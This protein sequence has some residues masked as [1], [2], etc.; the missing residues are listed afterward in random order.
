MANRSKFA[1][2]ETKYGKSISEI[3]VDKL[4]HFGNAQDAA[5]DLR[6]SYHHFV[7]KMNELGIVKEPRYRLPEAERE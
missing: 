1:A 6:I 2:L 7:R 4:N 3:M 5:T